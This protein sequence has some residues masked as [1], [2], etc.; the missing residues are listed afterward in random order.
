MT[1]PTTKRPTSG[2][3]APWAAPTTTTENGKTKTTNAT[4]TLVVKATVDAG[5]HS[6][7]LETDAVIHATETHRLV[8]G[9]G[10]GPRHEQQQGLGDGD[11][12]GHCQ[13]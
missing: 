7:A 2:P 5:T 8:H 9:P 3:S 6:Q 4:A 1:A 12:A 10:T 11:A 13:R